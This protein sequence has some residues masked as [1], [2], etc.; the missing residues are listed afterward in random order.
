MTMSPLQQDYDYHI[1]EF[2]K[3]LRASE[4]EVMENPL[5]TQIYG[6]YNKVMPFLT[7][8]IQNSMM[9]Q[10]AVLIYMKLVKSDRSDYTP[11]F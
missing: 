3:S 6:T 9:Q 11:D 10:D 8:A 4:F 2:I 5:S 7:Q 1:K